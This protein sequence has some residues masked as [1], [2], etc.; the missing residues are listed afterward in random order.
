MECPYIRNV[1]FQKIQIDSNYDDTLFTF[2]AQP[3]HDVLSERENEDT[4]EVS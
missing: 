1:I 2:S 3:V 4:A